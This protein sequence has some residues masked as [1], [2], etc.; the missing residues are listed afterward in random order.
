MSFPNSSAAATARRAGT[1]RRAGNYG[2]RT[3]RRARAATFA[4][5]VRPQ[6]ANG[7]RSSQ[8]ATGWRPPWPK[9]YGGGGLS[10]KQQFI[11]NE[12]MAEARAPGVGGMGISMVGPTL[13]A[14][15]T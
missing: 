5:A 15:G 11:L 14:H 1:K 2:A 8:I 9:E 13:M 10:V 4:S 6:C 7:A 12:E 3:R